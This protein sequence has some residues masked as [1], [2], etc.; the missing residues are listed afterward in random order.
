L[1]LLTSRPSRADIQFVDFDSVRFHVSTPDSKTVV[2][3]SMAI[4]CWPDLA[5]YGARESLEKEYA[6]YILPESETEAEYNVSLSIDLER[7][8]A[9]AG[10][11][12]FCAS[13]SHPHSSLALHL[14]PPAPL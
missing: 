14:P 8:P 12:A 1:L 5:K 6:G 2:L 11:S 13:L 7:I 9:S 10:E 4:Q 3:L